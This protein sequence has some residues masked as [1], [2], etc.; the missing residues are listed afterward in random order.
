MIVTPDTVIEIAQDEVGYLEKSLV[1]YKTDKNCI[2]SKKS[3]AGR[4]NITKYGYEMHK[5]YPVTMDEFSYWCDSFVDWCF[6]KAYGVATAK[7]LLGGKFDDYTVSSAEMYKKHNAWYRTPKAGDQVFLTNGSRI[8][9]TG[10]VYKVYRHYIYTV[11]GNTSSKQVLEPN[12]GCVAQKKYALGYPNIAGYGRPKYDV[13]A[14]CCMGDENSDI[15]TLQSL[16][17]SRG[18]DL[19]T[20]GID[21]DF[22]GETANAVKRFRADN[23]LKV[24]GICDAQC[25]QLLMK[26]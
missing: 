24:S 3:G 17:M 1:A 13:P 12:G 4:D 21:G 22:G 14:S 6:Y 19:P 15:R 10:I 18:Y 11:E 8:C 5:I 20:Y 7:S 25:W 26:G 23:G 16:L 2:Y 9:H